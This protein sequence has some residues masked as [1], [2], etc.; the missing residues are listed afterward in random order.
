MEIVHTMF[1]EIKGLIEIIWNRYDQRVGYFS[2]VFKLEK[3]KYLSTFN[4]NNNC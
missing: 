4:N 1:D 3:Y 2:T